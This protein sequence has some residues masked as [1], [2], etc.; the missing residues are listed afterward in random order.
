MYVRMLIGRY[1]GEVRDVVAEQALGLI[2]SGL[3]TNASQEGEI[4]PPE[5]QAESVQDKSKGKGKKK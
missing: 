5:V 4:L 1:A 3:A 2:A